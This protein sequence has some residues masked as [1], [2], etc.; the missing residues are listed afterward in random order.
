MFLF[1]MAGNV[2][3]VAVRLRFTLFVSSP[4][5][6]LII[7]AAQ[8]ILL[9]SMAPQHLLINASWLVGSGGTILLDLIVISQVSFRSSYF[10][11]PA[12]RGVGKGTALTRSA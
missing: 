4:S 9:T 7:E 2:T 8:S 11:V 6:E 12:R 5:A 10:V 3:Y 1:A